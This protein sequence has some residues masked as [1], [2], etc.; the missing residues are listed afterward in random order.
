MALP[1]NFKH[2]ILYPTIIIDD[3]NDVEQLRHEPKILKPAGTRDF[4]LNSFT[5]VEGMNDDYGSL[6]VVIP[7]H[8]NALTDG[9]DPRRPSTILPEWT[10]QLFLNATT[11][12]GD[13]NRWFYGKIKDVIVD[14]PG[15]AQQQIILTCIGWGVILKD[16]M[17]RLVRNQLKDEVVDDGETLDKTDTKARLDELIKDIFED[18]DHY[19]DDNIPQL[20]NITVTSTTDGT[21]I[22]SECLNTKIPNVNFTIS[23]FASAVSTL[24]GIGKAMWRIDHDRK[25]VIHDPSAHDSQFL[26]S[27][28]LATTGATANWD[29][30]KLGYL[31]NTPLSWVDTSINTFYSFIHAFGHFTPSLYA[32]DSETPD[33][34]AASNLDTR[35]MAI[36]IWVNAVSDRT[37]PDKDNI[38]K[39]A[40]RS[41][42]TGTPAATGKIGIWG[43]DGTGKPN[44]EDQRRVIELNKTTL[45]ALGTSTPAPWFEIPVKPK[46]AI[47]PGDPL[48]IV[49]PIYGSAANTFSVNYK[50]GSQNYY[51]S[52]DGATWTSRVGNCAYR[53]YEAKRLISTLEST[54]AN[55]LL[56]EPRERLFPIRSDLEEKTVRE[57][58]IAVGELLGRK[59]RLYDNVIISPPINKPIVGRFLKI[60]DSKTGLDIQANITK[61]RVSG[62]S[63]NNSTGAEQLELSLD[64][65][66]Y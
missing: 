31:L 57:T 49:F 66:H 45:Q 30:N 28:D 46:L 26:L 12:G 13:G 33:T 27:N 48:H 11:P 59:R 56:S 15:T 51:D 63:E 9:T 7:D 6:I 61:L 20:T 36:P 2:N 34:N 18:V 40:I 44:F 53:V 14:R 41:I 55:R 10:I 19:V 17:T 29:S 32:K 37:A 1:S 64:D 3:G 42:K 60:I 16:R 62:N 35:W 38:F 8:A 43:D 47:R 25:L 24:V 21:G 52:A 22:C 58:L 5:M 4:E 50:S 54:E 39:I 23:T 65:F